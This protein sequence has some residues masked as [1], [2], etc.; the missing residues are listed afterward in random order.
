MKKWSASLL[1][2]LILL[3]LAFAASPVFHGRVEAALSAHYV[4]DDDD[5][6]VDDADL[7]SASEG[8]ALR[9]GTDSSPDIMRLV[10]ERKVTIWKG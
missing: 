8:Y 4:A 3:A 5:D 1:I 9:A 2:L 10:K 6:E 7:P